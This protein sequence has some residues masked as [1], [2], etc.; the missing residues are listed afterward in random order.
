MDV[1]Y[2]ID[3]AKRALIELAT[4]RFSGKNS[5]V[6]LSGYS[7]ASFSYPDC[8]RLT[9]A[10]ED[11][12]D[13]HEVVLRVQGA[14]CFAQLPPIRSGRALPDKGEPRFIKQTIRLT[15]FGAEEFQKAFSGIANIATLMGEHLEHGD[16]ETWK[17]ERY[18]V[19]QA[20]DIGNR[21][22]LHQNTEGDAV[23]VSLPSNVDPDGVLASMAG[24]KWVHTED[25][26]VKYFGMLTSDTGKIKYAPIDPSEFKLGD[27]VEAQF[28][29]VAVRRRGKEEVYTLKLVLRALT[30]L[31]A[32]HTK[33]ARA[34]RL[35]QAVRSPQTP[36]RGIKRTVGYLNDSD[37][38]DEAS[39][40]P[41]AKMTRLS[42][43]DTPAHRT[44]YPMQQG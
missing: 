34:N 1:F 19:W 18:K 23:G 14:L 13:I 29:A 36:S 10:L 3:A 26:Q 39:S 30:M 40:V 15:G 38:G 6:Q 42:V 32:T 5:D 12:Q 22:F 2:D 35:R 37:D 4:E 11:P 20:L 41:T 8:M 27:I 31:D 28:S 43:S 7:E 17:P 16:I 25:N 33:A 44:D 24:D 9:M 21:Y